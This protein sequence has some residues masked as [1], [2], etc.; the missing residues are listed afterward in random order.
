[1]INSYKLRNFKSFNSAE[2]SFTKLNV[3]S[4]INGSGKSSIIQSL[5][6]LKSHYEYQSPN[7]NV[8][9]LNNNYC[10]LGK[11]Q[12]I[13]HEG[14]EDQIIKLI[15][16]VDHTEFLFSFDLDLEEF[17]LD[18]LQLKNVTHERAEI[19]TFFDKV[20]Y[21]QASRVGPT[22]LQEKNDYRVR[23]LRDIGM[24]GEFVY[25]YLNIFGKQS[26]EIQDRLHINAVNSTLIENTNKW[27]QDICPGISLNTDYIDGTDLV[28]LNYSFERKLGISNNYRST[29]VGF[30]ISYV[31][32]VIVQCLKAEKGDL[33]I[34]DTPEA[35]LHPQGQSKLGELFSKTASDG[36]Q[37]IVETHSDH[38]INGIRKSVVT[39]FIGPD[40]VNFYFFEMVDSGNNISSHT[41]ILSP[42]L[43]ENAKFDFW[44]DGFFDEWTK[45]LNQ[46]LRAQQ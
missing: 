19:N 44:P 39:G 43:D 41:N 25:H 10:Q 23:N 22:V 29:N 35:H 4:G 34:I 36:V 5:L 30:G 28:G 2:L 1:M 40:D 26:F 37:I 24:S 27:L 9:N 20:Y 18:Y 42:K 14:A 33:L 15:L 8:I 6:L 38:V 13:F 31:L 7:Y 3:L 11:V 45:S 17:G 12:D 21:L 46:I 32:P 16:N